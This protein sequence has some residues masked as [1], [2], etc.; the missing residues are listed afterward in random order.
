MTS[1]A[2]PNTSPAPSPGPQRPPAGTRWKGSRR[3]ISG[4]ALAIMGVLAAC[5]G[6]LGQYNQEDG[7]P[8]PGG[9]L[10]IAVGSGLAVW[11]RRLKAQRIPVQPKARKAPRAPEPA[12]PARAPKPVASSAGGK[13]WVMD[14]TPQLQEGWGF[15]LNGRLSL[16]VMDKHHAAIH[17]LVRNHGRFVPRGRGG[18]GV[19]ATW[20]D[21][22]AEPSNRYDSD[23]VRVQVRGMPVAYF[24]MEWKDLAHEHLKQA[25]RK[26]VR[27]PVVVRWW[28]QEEY[29]WAFGS[30]AEAESF[31]AWAAQQDLKA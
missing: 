9:L 27:I 20:A 31:A 19:L 28:S 15:V 14:I 25:G 22:I 6:I 12:S 17:K 30:M 5:D 2:E 23:A 29:V 7:N 24:A 16:Y 18:N 10:F 4:S 8:L 21:I 26:P 13:V 11:G 3:T 1:P